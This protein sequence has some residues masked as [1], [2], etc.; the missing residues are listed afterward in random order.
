[1]TIFSKIIKGELPCN[2]VLENDEFLA[3]HDINPKA[4]IHIL[5]IPKVEVKNFQEVTP[6]IMAKMTSFIQEVTTLLGLDE[7]GYRLITNNGD[8]GGQEVMHLH[9]HLLG[10][11]R[12]AWGHL[13]DSD[14][15]NFF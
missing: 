11:A 5:I 13:T 12:L 15:K 7:S 6:E 1:M 3:F 9:F 8:N 4:P 2:K 14:S 10:G